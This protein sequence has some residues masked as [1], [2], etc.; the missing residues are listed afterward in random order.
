MCDDSRRVCCCLCRIIHDSFERY[1]ALLI[2]FRAL[3]VGYGV[4]VIG[5][6]ALS[7]YI[8]A[9]ERTHTHTH[10]HEWR[11]DVRSGHGCILL[12]SA[13]VAHTHTHT[14]EHTNTH[15]YTHT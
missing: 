12:A 8:H 6:R 15:T 11:D 5:C 14:H 1:G 3:L 10:I 9:R 2:G 4:L 7:Q 13:F